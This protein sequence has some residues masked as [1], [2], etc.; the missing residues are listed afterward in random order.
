[1]WLL[2]LLN[3]VSLTW[4]PPSLCLP[5]AGRCFSL[6]GGRSFTWPWRWPS[7]PGRVRS[8][9]AVC[10]SPRRRC[11]WSASVRTPSSRPSPSQRYPPSL[12]TIRA[13]SERDCGPRVARSDINAFVVCR[14][15]VSRS[16]E[17]RT[18]SPSA[19][20]SRRWPATQRWHATHD[21]AHYK[22]TRTH[23]SLKVSLSKWKWKIYNTVP[24]FVIYVGY[25]R[26]TTIQFKCTFSQ[27]HIFFS[28]TSRRPTLMS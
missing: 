23:G 16:R 17:I 13:Q 9:P 22:C 15:S 21:T 5:T 25:L 27:N 24:I 4:V 1:M 20:S 10:S 11:L 28:K 19:Y 2:P 12:E 7:W 14:S 26:N 6:W 3:T 8:T 18:S